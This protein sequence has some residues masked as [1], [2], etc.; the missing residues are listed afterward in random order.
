M[1]MRK[2][3]LTII[4]LVL[5]A[6]AL[7]TLVTAW[8]LPEFQQ[9]PL[10]GSLT[11]TDAGLAGDIHTYPAGSFDIS[12]Y[13]LGDG[14]SNRESGPRV[15]IT[16]RSAPGRWLWHTLRGQAFIAAAQG[17]ET[18]K[19]ERGSFFFSDNLTRTCTG[20]TLDAITSEGETVILSG[21]LDCSRG[22]PVGYTMTFQPESEKQLAFTL[23][24]D[25]PTMNRAYLTY[26]S[27]ADEHFFG[28]GEQFSYFDHKGR[29]VPIWVSEQGIGR[30][31]QPLTF[32]VDLVARSGGTPYSTY[33]PVP[34]YIT[35]RMRSLFLDASSGS[36]GYAV[37]DLR[38]DDRV[39][40]SAFSTGLTGRILYGEN[41]EALIEEYTAWAG[42]MRPLPDWI[43]DGA[44][45]GMQG[46]TERVRE[47]YEQL[48]S[49]SVPVAAFWLQD[50]VGQRETSF[51]KQLWWNWELDTDRYPDW[52]ALRGELESDGV[53]IMLYA[54]PQLA[55]LSALKPNLRR[56]LFA[57]A[58][59]A[60]YLVKQADGSPYLVQN[61]DFYAGM[62]DLTNPQAREWYRSVLADQML[63]IGAS[64]WMAD[65]G[66]SL[67]YDAVLA[68]GESGAVAHN[69][70]PEWWAQFNRE[71]VDSAENSSE[72]VFFNRAAY[73]RSPAYA[74]LFWEG[75][76]LVSWDAH[77][78]IK[79]AVTGLLSGGISGFSL[80]HSDIGG[81]TSIDN[82]LARYHRSKEL[83]LRWMELSAF[84]TVYR[85]H[86][87]N[88]PDL[89]A[90]FYSDDE[91]LDHFAR[92]ARIYKAWAPLRKRLVEEAARTGVPV[93][94]HLFIHY[95]DDPE[96]YQLSYQEFMLG[97]DVLVAPALDPGVEEVR[98]YLPA[99]TWVHLW[100]GK[101][102]DTPFDGKWFTVPAPLGE[103]AVF[104]KYN[105]ET[106]EDLVE[107][108]QAQGLI[109]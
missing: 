36:L 17:T 7:A 51:G 75:D 71:L 35:S 10:N 60:G 16:H 104:Y 99:G 44:V 27:D 92:C 67:P 43:L 63:A 38:Q 97:S 22:A 90:Q 88:L 65:Y 46:G 95:P 91:T 14:A 11:L 26:A 49:R 73:Q 55:D 89:N 6:L 39:Q 84:T 80:N 98:V 5:L 66:E 61:T 30:G 103:P 47:V 68:S 19:E 78:G 62:V 42:R 15:V 85:T 101:I 31:M 107:D 106:G 4:P 94:R 37:F 29:R 86:E 2:R 54:S 9:R 32:L 81:Y 59:E 56:N 87:G 50:W 13:A 48:K 20:Q 100:S 3:L 79:S 77:D 70:Y 1:A 102:Y 96:V 57:E 83:L 76:Q 53:K 12:L 52:E 41:P 72:L 21:R 93:A 58:K 69:R 45:V 28:F 82:P 33:A 8:A 34:H 108:F 64:G 18:V 109:K 23:A 25:D 74:T 40:I 24:F 105:T